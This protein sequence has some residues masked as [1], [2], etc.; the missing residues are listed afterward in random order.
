[1]VCIDILQHVC[2]IVVIII[3]CPICLSKI[4]K[5]KALKCC[6]QKFC[7]ACIDEALQHSALCPMCQTPQWPLKGNQPVGSM[8][9]E[10]S[11]YPNLPGF[12]KCHTIKIHYYFPNGIQ[13][14]NH[15]SPGTTMNYICMHA[16]IYTHNMYVCM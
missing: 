13:G 16:C 12:A 7:I 9:S 5:P 6:K 11:Y 8:R 3:E 1:M 4:T 15:P 10:V 2:F 14:D